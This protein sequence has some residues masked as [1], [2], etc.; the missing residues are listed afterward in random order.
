MVDAKPIPARLKEDPASAM[1][2]KFGVDISNSILYQKPYLAE[3]D[4]VFFLLVGVLLI[5]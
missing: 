2:T 4:L 5:L 3:F 1:K